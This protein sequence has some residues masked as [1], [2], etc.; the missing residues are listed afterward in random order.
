MYG[1]AFTAKLKIT[2]LKPCILIKRCQ[3]LAA[4]I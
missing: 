1:T 3:S 4:R 2:S